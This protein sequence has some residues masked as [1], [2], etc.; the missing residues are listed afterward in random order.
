MAR[1][2]LHPGWLPLDPDEADGPLSGDAF[3][4]EDEAFHA[5]PGA[6]AADDLDA[7]DFAVASY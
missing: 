1:E 6:D 4:E 5:A 7:F 2:E 3:F